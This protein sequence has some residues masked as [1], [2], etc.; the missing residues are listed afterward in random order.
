VEQS[1]SND[2]TCER[3]PS[4]T[5][6]SRKYCAVREATVPIDGPTSGKAQ[7][8]KARNAACSASSRRRPPSRIE[9]GGRIAPPSHPKN[10]IRAQREMRLRRE[11]PVG[12]HAGMAAPTCGARSNPDVVALQRHAATVRESLHLPRQCIRGAEK[13]KPAPE[14]K[15]FPYMRQKRSS[16]EACGLVA[17]A[18]KDGA[19]RARFA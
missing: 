17:M 12:R 15:Q 13:V 10:E 14:S 8:S 3:P 9:A 7:E 5:R 4:A 2:G 16:V 19:R 6:R 18:W 11:A 1:R